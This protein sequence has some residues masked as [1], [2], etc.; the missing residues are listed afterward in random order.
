[1]FILYIHTYSSGGGSL[2]QLVLEYAFE[3]EEGKNNTITPRWPVWNQLLYESPFAGQ[4]YMI[5][6]SE[7]QLVSAG[8]T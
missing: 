2:Y 6:D 7:K 5:Y 1:V 4:L 8:G 3:I